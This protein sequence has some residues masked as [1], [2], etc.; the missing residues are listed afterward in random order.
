MKNLV[1]WIC[2]GVVALLSILAIVGYFFFPFWSIKVDFTLTAAQL[3][4]M[5][6]GNSDFEVDV[7]EVV[8]EEGVDLSLSLRITTGIVLG[9]LNSNA[10][11]TV[12]S[13][14]ESNVDGIIDQLAPT[15]DKLMSGVVKSVAKQTVKK[16]VQKQFEDYL[17]SKGSESGKSIEERLKDAGLDELLDEKIDT[18][19]ENL[20]EGSAKKDDVRDEI[21]IAVDDIYESF[22]NSSDEELS[23]FTLTESNRASIEKTVDDNLEKFAD[24]NGVIDLS[25]F[26]EELLSQALE[27]LVGSTGGIVPLAAESDGE[28][29]SSN[30]KEA[31][32]DA[33]LDALDGFST[34]IVWVLRA[35]LV[36][37]VISS[38]AWIYILIKLLVKLVKKGEPT[39]KLKMPIILG[40][41]PYL[42]LVIIPAIAMSLVKGP[43]S[44]LLPAEIP[45]VSVAF[46]SSGLIALIAAIVCIGISIFY[47]IVRKQAKKKAASED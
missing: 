29:S 47:I 44:K 21:L 38:L 26:I 39:V 17:K 37:W 46:A 22:K 24:E 41:L 10:E 5:L 35:F 8:G 9:S 34:Y 7:N 20:F 1:V 4:K 28:A 25:R 30:L 2:N 12:D 15:L 3:E 18:I 16:E 6:E 13:L 14:V 33:L 40:W 43:L 23:S 19:I 32:K 36:L 11:K 27:S 42:I 45:S 31:L